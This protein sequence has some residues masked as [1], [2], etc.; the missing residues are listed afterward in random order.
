MEKR[1][2]F[3]IALAVYAILGCLAWMT[4]SSASLAAG[5]GRISIR[6]L[7][8]M[9]LAFFALRTLLQWKTEQTG[10]QDEEHE[11]D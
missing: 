7:T 4:M 10:E 3:Y 1:K 2:R 8:V 11:Q 9:I 6:L 5:N